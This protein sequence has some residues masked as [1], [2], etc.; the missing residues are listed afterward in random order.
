MENLSKKGGNG[1]C[2]YKVLLFRKTAN[3]WKFCRRKIKKQSQKWYMT[4]SLDRINFA[5]NVNIFIQSK[6]FN[7]ICINKTIYS[8]VN[9]WFLESNCFIFVKNNVDVKYWSE[10]NENICQRVN[11]WKL[12]KCLIL[13]CIIRLLVKHILNSKTGLNEQ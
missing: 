5:T 11:E 3:T 9:S 4:L 7:W 2:F 13:L 6:V 1:N 12:F 10:L 8:G